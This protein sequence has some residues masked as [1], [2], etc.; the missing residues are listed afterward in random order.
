MRRHAGEKL[1]VLDHDDVRSVAF[2]ESAE[3]FVRWLADGGAVTDV[4]HVREA[5]P[6]ELQQF[7]ARLGVEERA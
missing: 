3:A 4:A 6:E 5:T 2:A 7:R 1:W